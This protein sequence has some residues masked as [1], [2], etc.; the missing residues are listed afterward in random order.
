MFIDL[1]LQQKKFGPNNTCFFLL[2]L[3]NSHIPDLML[4]S[5]EKID[6]ITLKIINI[7]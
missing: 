6:M 1:S 7:V 5:G 4:R 2:P 3:E